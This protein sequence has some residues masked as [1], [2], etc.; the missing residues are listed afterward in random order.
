MYNKLFSTK[1]KRIA[2][3]L[4]LFAVIFC[5]ATFMIMNHRGII[6]GELIL[7]D[8]VQSISYS[9]LLIMFLAGL[10]GL[11]PAMLSFLLLFIDACIYDVNSAYTVS[12]YVIAMVGAYIMSNRKA[13]K[14]I[15]TT[16]IGGLIMNVMLG[17]IWATIGI[18]AG[19]EGLAGIEWSELISKEFYVAGEVVIYCVAMYVFL[20]CAPDRIKC[21]FPMGVD[22]VDCE[23]LPGDIRDYTFVHNS[24]ISRKLTWIVIV[25]ALLLG[26]AAA[27]FAAVMM[28][29]VADEVLSSTASDLQ[30]FF[31]RRKPPEE[32][33]S[34]SE[35]SP[36][37][38]K[39][40]TEEEATRRQERQERI[41]QQQRFVFN[42]AG[43]A[44]VMKLV[45]MILNVAIPLIVLETVA[46]QWL[47]A[48][49]VTVLANS[50]NG[51]AGSDREDQQ[52]KLKELENMR[53]KGGD[54]ICDLYDSVSDMAHQINKNVDKMFREAE[55][56]EEVRVAQRAAES[57]T[58]FLNNVSH[59]LRTP[60]N[61]VLGLDEMIVRETTEDNIRDY[62]NDIQSAGKSLLSLVND[63]LDSS[64]LAEGK[65][66]IM[67]EEYELGSTINDIINMISVKAKDKDLEF[68]LNVD[69]HMPHLL[70]GD[71]IRIKQIIVNILTNA[72][73]YT[74][75]GGFTLDLG[76]KK[77]SEDEILLTC[78]VADTGIG[79]KEEDMDKLFK[80]FER[81]EESR[82]RTIEGT[83]LGMNIVQQLLAL[84]DSELQVES[85][86]GEGS[87]F[88]FEVK[89]KVV[90][91]DEMGDF[92][93]SYRRSLENADHDEQ[94]FIAPEAQIL[95]TDD[96][97]MNLTVICGLLKPT[98]IQVDTAQS[99]FETLDMVREKKYDLIFL[100]HRMP[101]MDGMETLKRMRELDDSKNGDTPV[102]SLTANAI[103]GARETY[104]TA[105]FTDYLSKPI[106]SARLQK[107]LLNYLPGEKVVAVDTADMTTASDHMSTADTQSDRLRGHTILPQSEGSNGDVILSEAKNPDKGPTG[108][109]R[110]ERLQEYA[111]I[112][113]IEYSE[114]IRNCYSEEVLLDAARDYCADIIKKA[115]LIE[116]Y[117]GEGDY[118]NYTVLVH[119]LKSSSR[120]IGA[121]SL[122]EEAKRLEACGD[123]AK[124]GDDRAAFE[125]KKRTPMLLEIYRGYYEFMAPVFGMPEMGSEDD[126]EDVAD[127]RPEIPEDKLMEGINC[128]RDLAEAF[129][130]DSMD[131]I[132][133]M[134]DEYRMPD[135]FAS[136]YGRIKEE[137]HNVDTSALL[138]VI[139]AYLANKG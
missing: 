95:V 127:D 21:A 17:M 63:I 111:Q 112:P 42:N 92:M 105:G 7:G 65:M 91:W 26:V 106:D 137:I 104:L 72:V 81:I 47:V 77:H 121:M 85:K 120:L 82:N 13:F 8:L 74:D 97:P 62:A 128:L 56:E 131:C 33:A 66:E 130:F 96:T 16:V 37:E 129:D 100:D 27:S 102:I 93:E 124:E 9:D 118:E 6:A 133:D 138:S 98:Q 76:F 44:F 79:I 22:Y 31:D 69:E 89:Q 134:M 70:F 32:S 59:E 71:E 125:I 75:K 126:T 68:K 94:S 101:E 14:H 51:F 109:I 107:L 19:G 90:S 99:G 41:E 49:P 136:Y 139:D 52:K 36:P 123:K 4:C 115:D 122:S 39:T 108:N 61:A 87:T 23:T 116:Q 35:S 1:A 58:N 110:D 3:L 50:L 20:N 114:A 67:P 117:E 30:G 135:D 15:W 45:I 86:Y 54:E 29:S 88:S 34:G 43:A 60:I 12:I 132:T 40:E 55:L 78:S 38:K 48:R 83:G 57:Q 11:A 2:Y 84:M 103:S 119:A 10:W 46:V 73:K 24:R 18:I 80:R 113:G 53:L 5:T 28:P 25:Q 64:K